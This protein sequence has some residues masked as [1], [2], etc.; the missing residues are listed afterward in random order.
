MAQYNLMEGIVADVERLTFESVLRKYDGLPVHVSFCTLNGTYV[1]FYGRIQS[2][3]DSLD[4]LVYG[5]SVLRIH[6]T[7]IASV[8]LDCFYS[9]PGWAGEVL[10]IEAI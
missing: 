10:R 2:C 7:D 6:R 3:G 4:L 9:N 8:H 1:E 5:E